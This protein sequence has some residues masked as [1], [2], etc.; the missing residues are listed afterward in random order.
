MIRGD[1]GI[2]YVTGE[3]VEKKV[4]KKLFWS[5]LLSI[6]GILLAYVIGMTTSVYA[7]LN[8]RKWA[9]KTIT[10]I[11]VILFS[12]PSFWFAIMLLWVFANPEIFS[13][14]PVSGVKPI[15]GFS[16]Q[17]GEFSKLMSTLPYLVL[18][19][20]CYAYSTYAVI[21][22]TFRSSLLEQMKL[23]YTQTAKAKGLNEKQI[24]L[25]HVF[26]NA[27]LP[28]ITLFTTSFPLAIGGSLVIETIFNI[29]GMGNEIMQAV[30]HQDYP[31]LIAFFVLSGIVTLASYILADI[32]YSIVDPRITLNN[33]S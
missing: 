12:I 26:R 21:T 14:L 19:T 29:P 7:T 6:I 33:L 24:L 4:R 11:T 10:A 20:I 18:P 30:Y 3:P 27:L 32:V 22:Q 23:D 8:R 2:S 28:I 31:V 1:F 25:N 5:V 17:T 16:L 13:I 15:Q 9:D